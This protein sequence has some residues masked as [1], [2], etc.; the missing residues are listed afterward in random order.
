M[1]KKTR[2]NILL[3]ITA[4]IW[5]F[6]FVAQK[7]STSLE[8]F[9][10]NCIRFLVGAIALLPAIKFL[11]QGE[12]DASSEYQKEEKKNLILGGLVCGSILAAAS[13]LQQFGI[14]FETDAGKAGFITTLYIL[15]V[16]ILGIFL[17]KKVSLRKWACVFL[18]AVGFYFLTMA[19]KTGGF[20]LE[21]GDL[22]VLLCA[23]AFSVHI[24]AVDH[25]SPKCNGIKLSCLQ[26]LV[27]SVL[28]LICMLIFE[29]PNL[30]LILDCWLP[31]LYVGIFSSGVGYTFQVLAQKDADPT[32]ASLIMSLE[33]VFAVIAGVIVFQERLSTLELIG[34][35][36]IFTAVIISQLS[37][38]DEKNVP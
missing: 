37:F 26:F 11:G 20:K 18:G 34:C 5:G 15:I 23:F 24:L 16:P 12:I 28:S 17:K 33:S 7:A 38:N 6:A 21:N 19:G 3:L 13:N 27:A 36:I 29:S 30:K 8:P 35:V 10:Y 31:I 9:T 22:F 2:A 32:T 25:F 14:Y 1:S 4:I